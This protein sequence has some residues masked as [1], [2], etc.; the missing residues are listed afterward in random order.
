MIDFNLNELKKRM[1][2]ALEVLSKEFIGL[3]TNRASTALLEP[4]MVEAYEG[5]VPLT[6]VS[7]ISAPEARLLSVQV[8]DKS[9]VKNVEK[10][11]RDAGLGLNPMSEGTLIRIPLPELS[12]E[13]RQ[14]I[15]KI[16]AK[17][18][19]QARVSV[20]NVRRDGMDL[21]KKLE[22]EGQISKD[23]HHRLEGEIQNLTDEYIKKIDHH[24][25]LKEKDLLQ[26]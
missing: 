21:L 3:R 6:Q 15:A 10:A 9:L 8:W 14:E 25:S 2:G 13:R 24:L 1:N 26:V 19:E 12:Q 7:S 23:E 5:K 11:I 16:A 18:A 20:R 22:K 17:Y 4:I